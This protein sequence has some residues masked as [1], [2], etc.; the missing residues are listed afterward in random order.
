[1]KKQYPLITV[2]I[3]I[4]NVEPYLQKCID[5]ICMQTY[6]R[7]EIILVDDGSS[8]NCGKICDKNSEVDSRIVVIHKENGGLS[9][10]RN[11]GLDI[12][13][14]EYIAFV[15]SD[16][17]IHPQ[18]I[19]ILLN[20]SFQYDSDISQCDFLRVSEN[21]L[22]LSLNSQ[23]KICIYNNKQAI[24]ELC[25]TK[26]AVKY[27]V[28]WNK[29]Y[30]RELFAHIRYPNGRIHE[31]EF[32]TYLLLWKANKI[33]V[34]NQYL[35][36]YLQRKTSIMGKPFS[37]KRLDV[38]DAYKERLIFLKRNKLKQEYLS[39]LQTMA[40]VMQTDYLLLKENIENCEDICNRLLVNKERIEKILNH[41]KLLN[42]QIVKTDMYP[43]QSKI[44]LY[45]AGYWGHKYYKWINENHY[46]TIV[47]WVDNAWTDIIDVDFKI[48]PID[49][50]FR[51]E[52][53]YLLITLK[54]RIAQEE[55]TQ[56]LVS[57]GISKEKIISLF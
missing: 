52:F 36:Y 4:Y 12:A 35:Y 29:L 15:D 20:L 46:G 42:N 16:D 40:N 22:N 9:S 24:Y 25:C 47:G 41:S 53:D 56:N 28:A 11:A 48:M 6:S 17:T 49:A 32:T 8:D 30:K 7:L 10:A 34:I 39:T 50:I 55:I 26:N 43:E 19:E 27:A 44:I 1:M 31:D 38:L 33:V 14:G 13:K 57:W 2:I 51:I 45:G 23:Q 5:S 18:F 21:S 54:D 37:I 3:P